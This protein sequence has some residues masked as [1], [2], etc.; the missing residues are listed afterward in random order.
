MLHLWAPKQMSKH[1]RI[2]A[3]VYPRPPVRGERHPS[4]RAGNNLNQP[5]PVRDDHGS[6]IEMACRDDHR[7]F[8]KCMGVD[9]KLPRE[10]VK[11]IAGALDLVT[12]QITVEHSEVDSTLSVREAKFVDHQ[13]VVSLVV[14]A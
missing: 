11:G 7:K 3:W 6:G 1:E 12:M 9:R 14:M 5:T 13:D 4:A 2:D 10:P 8:L